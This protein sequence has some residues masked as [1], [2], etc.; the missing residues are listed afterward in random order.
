MLS[1][2]S[3]K[4][5]STVFYFTHQKSEMNACKTSY[6]C[7]TDNPQRTRS[8]EARFDFLCSFF[9]FSNSLSNFQFR[10]GYQSLSFHHRRPT[11]SNNPPTDSRCQPTDSRLCFH[12]G[13]RLDSPQSIQDSL[14]SQRTSVS[15]RSTQAS[16]HSR[17][18]TLVSRRSIQANL[19]FRRPLVS[20]TRDF[21]A[22]DNPMSS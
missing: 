19:R 2:C 15:R 21:P 17:R 8:Y 12:L 9:H 22:L 5:K 6:A 16:L 11:L 13:F 10:L 7:P 14:L 18:P 4:R 20:Q 1:D 3:S